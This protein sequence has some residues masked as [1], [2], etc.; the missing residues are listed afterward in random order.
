MP[1]KT[2]G[3]VLNEMVETSRKEPRRKNCKAFRYVTAEVSPL[4][5]KLSKKLQDSDLMKTATDKEREIYDRDLRAL[6]RDVREY[7]PVL[8]A[9]DE[10]IF[11][12]FSTESLA[13][14]QMS[15]MFH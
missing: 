8:L 11:G 15:K 6:V 14:E 12:N 5:A 2:L 7:L 1:M 3:E 13:K 10:A 4:I 9:L